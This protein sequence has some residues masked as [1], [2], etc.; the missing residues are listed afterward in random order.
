L[1]FCKVSPLAL[2]LRQ[3]FDHLAHAL[4]SCCPLFDLMLPLRASISFV[5]VPVHLT[6]MPICSLTYSDHTLLLKGWYSVP[7]PYLLLTFLLEVSFLQIRSY[8]FLIFCCS[9]FIA[10]VEGMKKLMFYVISALNFWTKLYFRISFRRDNIYYFLFIFLSLIWILYVPG[11][12][13]YLHLILHYQV[14]LHFLLMLCL[15]NFL[16]N[17]KL[18]VTHEDLFLH[19]LR[20]HL[21]ILHYTKYFS[22]DQS[23][24]ACPNYNSCYTNSIVTLITEILIIVTESVE[25]SIFD[26]H[27]AEKSCI[28]ATLAQ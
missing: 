3:V 24:C 26:I 25:K 20:R 10:F 7:N 5:V 22:A 18:L 8:F 12:S 16:S 21:L 23:S 4:P 13:D 15:W 1:S 6:N 9:C 27:P 14:W 2:C 19:K 11:I 28:V 17:L